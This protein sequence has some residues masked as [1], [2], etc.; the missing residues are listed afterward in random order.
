M[1]SFIHLNTIKDHLSDSGMPYVKLMLESHPEELECA[2]EHG[3]CQPN[4]KCFDGAS[5]KIS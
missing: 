2:L 1:T 4:A 5:Y 3:Y